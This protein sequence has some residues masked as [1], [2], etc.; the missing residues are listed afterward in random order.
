[1]TGKN[2]EISV[3]TRTPEFEYQRFGFSAVISKVLPNYRLHGGRESPAIK[4]KRLGKAY[5]RDLRYHF[6]VQ[7]VPEYPIELAL[8]GENGRFNLIDIS[9]GGLCFSRRMS[10][11]SEDSE[12]IETGDRLDLSVALNG[13]ERLQLEAKVIR[14]FYKDHFEYIGVKFLNLQREAR[15]IL[16]DTLHRIQRIKLA[17]RSGVY[18]T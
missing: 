8:S 14:K 18:Y 9:V 2:I 11:E 12:D 10:S 4:V 15:Q 5:E 13:N 17:K 7:P 16:Q 6:R 1:M 3:L